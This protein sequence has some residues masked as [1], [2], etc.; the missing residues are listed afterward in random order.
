MTDGYYRVTGPQGKVKGVVE[1]YRNT[2]SLGSVVHLQNNGN[3]L[4]AVEVFTR[5]ELGR[6]IK[7]RIER[8]NG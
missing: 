3:I 2:S 5:E 6:Y 7:E 1:F 4:E 8:A